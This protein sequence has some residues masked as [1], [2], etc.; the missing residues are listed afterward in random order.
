MKI[1]LTGSSGI[2][3]KNLAKTLRAYGHIV[4]T[5]SLRDCWGP[6]QENIDFS[7]IDWH[8]LLRDIDVVIHLSAFAHSCFRLSPH[9]IS[10]IY[11]LNTIASLQLALHSAIFGVK[12]FIYFSTSNICDSQSSLSS[13]CF[14]SLKQSASSLYADSKYKSE[15]FISTLAEHYPSTNYAIIRPSLVYGPTCKGNFK[16]LLRLLSLPLPLPLKS[17]RFKRNFIYIENLSHVIHEMC[18]RDRLEHLTYDAFDTDQPCFGEFLDLISKELHRKSLIFPVNPILSSLILKVLRL[19]PL[20][21]RVLTSSPGDRESLYT[22]LDID[23]PITTR[24]AVHLTARVW[25]RKSASL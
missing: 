20:L 6:Y 11:S 15:Q 9:N 19:S 3:G 13:N 7:L 17:L 2:I 21:S 4:T 10:Q 1:L 12:K 23:Q 5:H 24:E 14:P 8:Y 22:L 16:I 18:C 25:K